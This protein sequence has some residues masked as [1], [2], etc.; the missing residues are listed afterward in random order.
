MSA[1]QDTTYAEIMCT[2]LSKIAEALDELRATPLP[3]ELIFLYVQ[4]RTRLAKRDIEA[5]FNAIDELNAK[6]KKKAPT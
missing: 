5:V 2:N 4:K 1:E 6:V 3:R